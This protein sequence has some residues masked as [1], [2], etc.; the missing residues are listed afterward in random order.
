MNY[1]GLYV[2][3]INYTLG[4]VIF[5]AGNKEAIDVKRNAFAWL[6]LVSTFLCTFYVSTFYAIE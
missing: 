1:G 5:I 6:V 4:V 2:E 3:I